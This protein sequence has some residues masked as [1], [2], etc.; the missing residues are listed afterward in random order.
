MSIGSFL[1]EYKNEKVLFDLGIGNNHFSSPEGNCDGGEL[2]NN[3]KKAGLIKE[4][5]T[6]VI[7]SNFHAE[8]VG[9]TSMDIN[10]KRFLTF[11]N[12]DYFSSENEWN[13]W[14]DKINEPKVVFQY[15][16]NDLLDDL[17]P[18]KVKMSRAKQNEDKRVLEDEVKKDKKVNKILLGSF[19]VTLLI[20][21]LV[22]IAV[23]LSGPKPKQAET[24]IVIPDVTGMSITEAEA[25]LENL[26]FVV[27]DEVTERNSADVAEGKV[28]GTSPKIGRTL[29]NGSTITLIVSKGLKGFTLENYVGQSYFTVKA[30]LEANGIIVELKEEEHVE[31]DG[32][33]ANSIIS[34][35]KL[36]GEE[37]KTGETLTLTI[38]KIIVLYPD[39]TTYSLTDA[40]AFARKNGITLEEEQIETSSYPEG[41]IISQTKVVGEKVTEGD[42]IKVVVAKAPKVVVKEETKPETDNT[43]T[44]TNTDNTNT[45]TENTS[46]NTSTDNNTENTN[47]NTDNTSTNTSTSTDSNSKSSTVE[48]E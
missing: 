21:F 29:K 30:S 15:P 32:L 33:L 48:T 35:D 5:I 3:L 13:F 26:G 1:I 17:E 22:V 2:L 9:W 6:K 44:E 42:T 20:I 46:T 14:K 18:A 25:E 43:T 16:E 27:K 23:L 40:R 10:G 45:N 19:I 28:M 11:S 4:D 41:S 24:E 36:A 8:H 39:L 34:Q 7:Y 47:T 31:S 12:A 38:T 37:I